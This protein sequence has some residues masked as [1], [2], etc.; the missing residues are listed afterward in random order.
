MAKTTRDIKAIK[1][2]LKPYAEIK[3]NRKHEVW[4]FDPAVVKDHAKRLWVISSTPSTQREAL[5]YKKEL[6]A[7]LIDFE[8][9]LR[10]T[11]KPTLQK[12]VVPE[13]AAPIILSPA[14]STP[15]QKASPDVVELKEAIPVQTTEPVL[16]P[17]P[18]VSVQDLESLYILP[19]QPVAPA[20]QKLPIPE[21]P[22]GPVT[23]YLHAAHRE[24]FNRVRSHA[25]QSTT[26]INHKQQEVAR[27]MAEIQED[28]HKLNM[29]LQWLETAAMLDRDFVDIADFCPDAPV[30]ASSPT[31]VA[32]QMELLPPAPRQYVVEIRRG[33]AELGP[34]IEEYLR[35]FPGKI[36]SM[37]SLVEGLKTRGVNTDVK[38]I[39]AA[40][41]YRA[42]NKKE[43]RIERVGRGEYS[44]R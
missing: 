25:I 22:T 17:E 15:V 3:R 43:N 20:L 4:K 30:A 31:P 5:N 39:S 24:T 13:E 6:R 11:F 10:G 14:V 18:K 26:E 2:A 32:P 9:I 21:P 27:L 33:N 12:P 38:N 29:A 40:I 44:Y 34:E 1:C 42:K 36:F 23:G 7:I 8:G 37:H 35:S 19:T 41:Y 16:E 28:R